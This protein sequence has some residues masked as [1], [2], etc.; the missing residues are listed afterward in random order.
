MAVFKKLFGCPLPTDWLKMA[1]LKIFFSILGNDFFFL[2]FLLS[3]QQT[4]KF[5]GKKIFPPTYRPINFT[6]SRERASK[7]YF[8]DGLMLIG[9]QLST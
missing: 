1:R 9:Y 7:Y 5:S 2:L 6:L 8:K 3:R 4:L